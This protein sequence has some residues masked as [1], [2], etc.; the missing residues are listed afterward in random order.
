MP[1]K[2]SVQSRP[3]A[4]SDD[5]PDH[6]DRA[7]AQWAAVLPDLDTEAMAVLG[8]IWRLSNLA[9]PSIE[10]T[11]AKYGLERGE[12]DVVATLL[13]SGPPH[14]LTPTQL[15]SLM[16]VASGT[17]TH[18]LGKLAASGLVRR[19]KSAEDGRSLA[20]ELTAKGRKL[21]EQAFREDMASETALMAGMGKVDRAELAR[22]LKALTVVVEKNAER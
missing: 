17:L 8:R 5:K 19:V 13:R 22:L 9:R 1:A 2:E 12:F 6:V 21:T 10:A 11:F 15:Y 16:M 7:R 14:R 3:M 4:K 20:V 18:R